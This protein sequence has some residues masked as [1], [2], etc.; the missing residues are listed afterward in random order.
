M[1][2]KYLYRNQRAG[3]LDS[4]PHMCNLHN[5][6][7]YFIWHWA[8]LNVE[9]QVPDWLD[10][11]HPRIRVVFHD[12]IFN[13]MSDLPTFNSVAIE[14]NLHHIKDLRIVYL[15]IFCPASVRYFSN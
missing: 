14:V 9:I 10:L 11:T 3:K 6:I 15:F 13:D 2:Q 8:S 7:P 1:G 4:K 12:Q 5:A